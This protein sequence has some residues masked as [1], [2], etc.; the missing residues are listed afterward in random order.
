MWA[1]VSRSTRD[2]IQVH[3]LKGGITSVGRVSSNTIPIPDP[4]VSRFHCELEVNPET[5][6]LTLRDLE[7]KNGT[8]VNGKQIKSV[9]AL[10]A[11]DQIRIGHKA[12]EVHQRGAKT[13]FAEEKG[14]LRTQ[15][16]TPIRS[17]VCSIQA[18]NPTP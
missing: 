5:Q 11:D 13:Q 9:Q 6:E 10:Q 2:G 17:A 4:L 12:F 7:S 15:P 18:R 1:L 16:L 3:D 8:F 14:R